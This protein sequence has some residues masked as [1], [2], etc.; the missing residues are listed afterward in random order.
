VFDAKRYATG[1]KI[2]YYVIEQGKVWHRNRG[3][4]F[5]MRG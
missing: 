1:D 5:Q 3:E 4:A 2:V